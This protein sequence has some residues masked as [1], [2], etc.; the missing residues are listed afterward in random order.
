MIKDNYKLKG[1]RKQLVEDLKYKGINDEKIL[2]AILNVPRHYFIESGFAEW[3]YKD[4]PFAIGEDQTIS[5][6]Y[7]VAFM[8]SLLDIQIGDKVLEIGTGS[9]Y[10]ASVLAYLGAKVFTIERQEMLFHK[11]SKLLDVL[12]ISR[13]KL[14]LGDGYKGLPTLAPFDKIIVTAGAPAIPKTLIDQ[15]KK[16]GIMIIP[17]GNEI[18]EMIKITKIDQKTLRKESFGK[19][20]FV[21]F[22]PGINAVN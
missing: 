7:T 21:P 13:V 14:L 9:G 17:V 22:L 20:Q 10:Q 12:G 19:F 8:T 1:L 16:G 18:Q 3:A 11:T 6:P 15:L 2:E 5:Q 4:V